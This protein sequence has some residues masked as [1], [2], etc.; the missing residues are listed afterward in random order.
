MGCFFS[1]FIFR[2]ADNTAFD[3]WSLHHSPR[4]GVGET[5][6]EENEFSQQKSQKRTKIRNVWRIL[7]PKATVIVIYSLL[8]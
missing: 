4:L 8:E 5:Y 1:Q 2:V 7:D 3:T 6:Q